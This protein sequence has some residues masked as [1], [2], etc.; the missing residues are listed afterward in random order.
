MVTATVKGGLFEQYGTT[1]AQYGKG[2]GRRI[3]SQFLSHNRALRELMLTLDGIV[4]GS[5]ALA[6]NKRIAASEELGGVRAMETE[7][8]VNRATVN[9]D[10]VTINADLLSLSSKTYDGTPVA[11]LDG[12]PLGTR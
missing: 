3:V 10:V 6:T 8:L 2:S 9:G 1:L 4:P 7:V 5:T 12:N 11:N